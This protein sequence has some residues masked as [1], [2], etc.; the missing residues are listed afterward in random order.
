M[1]LGRT[2]EALGFVRRI[3]H[4]LSKIE[5][6]DVVLCPP[7]TVLPLLREVLESS[8]VAL[9]A[10]NM[11]WAEQ[12]AHTGEISPTMLAGLC[13]YV[14]LGHSER[15]ATGGRT[16]DDSAINRKVTAA[17]VAGLVP[18]ICVGESGEQRE[19]GS[20]DE[21][22]RRQ[23][24]RALA[25]I[26]QEQARR[27]VLAYEP[28]WAIGS[29]RP[30]TP[31]EANRVIALSARGAV[32]DDFGEQAAQRTRV[33]YG[34]SVLP[35]NIAAFTAMPEIDGALV[36]GASLGPEFVEL[37]LRASSGR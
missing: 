28:I 12:G 30:A 3:R 19:A 31:A 2:E 13:H 7:F 6:V 8:P 32:A 17:F 26:D 14:I 37:V 21:V 11:H 9:G 15:R 33:L 25:G 20:T 16:E 36:G 18:I 5:G 27:C 1:H 34:G 22:V 10:Q 24:S 29:G 23:V 4:P 35:D